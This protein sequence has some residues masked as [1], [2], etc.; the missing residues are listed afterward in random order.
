MTLTSQIKCCATVVQDDALS[1]N[2]LRPPLYRARRV[3]L[4][5]RVSNDGAMNLSACQVQ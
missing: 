5:S 2:A 3:A 1:A 4:K